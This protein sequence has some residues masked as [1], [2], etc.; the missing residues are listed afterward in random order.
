MTDFTIKGF[1][2]FE[3][4]LDRLNENAFEKIGRLSINASA[5]PLIIEMKQ[6]IAR[7]RLTG[8]LSD[9]IKLRNLPKRRFEFA[10]QLGVFA[11]HAHLVEFGTKAHSIEAGSGKKLS[12]V[13]GRRSVVTTEVDHPGAQAKPFIRPTLDKGTDGYFEKLGGEIGK[14][15]VK[16]LRTVR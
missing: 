6:R 11:P 2:E 15:I 9:S 16:E 12:F 13:A 10:R 14:R 5:K 4:Q 1:Q 8:T 3:K 7:F